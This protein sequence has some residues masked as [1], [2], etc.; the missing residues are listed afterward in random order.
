MKIGNCHIKMADFR[1]G[2]VTLQDIRNASKALA[3]P[4]DDYAV[5]VQFES[6]NESATAGVPRQV[7][8]IGINYNK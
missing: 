1:S 8:D 3:W 2:H 5:T 4:D 6:L 7:S